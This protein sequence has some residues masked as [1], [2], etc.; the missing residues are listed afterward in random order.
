MTNK[1]WVKCCCKLHLGNVTNQKDNAVMDQRAHVLT[2]Y[3][4]VCVVFIWWWIEP[5]MSL[6]PVYWPE[7]WAERNNHEASTSQN[8]ATDLMKCGGVGRI[9]GTQNESAAPCLLNYFQSLVCVPYCICTKIL[10]QVPS[11]SSIFFISSL[12]FRGNPK[13]HP[14]THWCICSG[15][16]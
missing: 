15:L 5:V 9:H 10:G 14:H 13:E 12:S 3:S 11:L 8:M 4:W 7:P 6:T 2:L 1:I 16:G